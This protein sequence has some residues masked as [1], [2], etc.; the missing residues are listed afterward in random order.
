MSEKFRKLSDEG[1]AMFKLWLLGGG[2]D[3]LP[4]NLL[5]SPEHSTS[6]DFIFSTVLPEFDNRYDFGKHLVTLFQD[7]PHL[8]IEND[9][10]F[11]SSLALVWFDSISSRNESGNRN[12]QEMARYILK[13]NWHDYRHLVRTPWILVRLH[14]V[15][16]K[17]L[18]SS[19]KKDGNPLSITSDT[20]EKIG[21]RQSLLRNHTVMKVLS[22]LYFDHELEQLK[23]RVTGKGPGTPIRTG[24]IVRQLAL[25]YDLERMPEKDIY[26]ILPREFDHWKE[27]VAL[28]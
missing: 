12:I 9:I 15:H 19:S 24:V 7:I 11:W 10:S 25:T 28:D 17:F 6:T 14:G 20:L 4:L 5:N 3:P 18:L 13:L 21:S 27:G 26:D 16:A 1:L 22:N 2:Q 23:P 8:E